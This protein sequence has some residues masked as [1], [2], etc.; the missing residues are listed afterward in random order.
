MATTSLTP[1]GLDQITVHTKKAAKHLRAINHKF[2]N[3]IIKIILEK[4]SI[5]VT[6]LYVIL[7]VEQSVCSQHLKILRDAG[8]VKSNR[9]GKFMKYSL[10]EGRITELGHLS[11]SI[12]AA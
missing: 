7:R 12:N 6:E 8:I 2:R 11:N 3:Q 1:E 10:Y 5:T 4:G 9:E